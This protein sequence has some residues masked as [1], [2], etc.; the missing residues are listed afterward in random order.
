MSFFFF[1]QAE[2]GIRDKLVTGVQ[3][4]ALPI[5]FVEL[6]ANG[7]VAKPQA[8]ALERGKVYEGGNLF[9]FERLTGFA[10]ERVLYVGDHIYGDIIRNRKASQWRTCFVVQELERE[11]EYIEH[12]AADVQ[13]LGELDALRA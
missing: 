6:N 12:N 5:S 1:F 8:E 9:D 13:R 10:G 3:T 4:C 7:T 2:D 11:I